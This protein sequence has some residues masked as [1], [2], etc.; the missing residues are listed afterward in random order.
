MAYP[1]SPTAREIVLEMVEARHGPFWL[2]L[3]LPDGRWGALWEDCLKLD[4]IDYLP[5]GDFS[6]CACVSSSRSEVEAYIEK[7]REEMRHNDPLNAAQF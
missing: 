1:S 7:E 4:I 5:I 2:L 6:A 3:Q